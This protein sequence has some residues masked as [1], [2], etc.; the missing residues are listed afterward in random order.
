MK[1]EI[2]LTSRDL[3]TLHSLFSQYSGI[4]RVRIFGS[5]A[6]G[7]YRRGSDL[8]LVIDGVYDYSELQSDI[9]ES[10]LPYFVDILN[11]K[12]IWELPLQE[13]IQRVGKVIY[14]R[15]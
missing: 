3:D 11:P 12:D 14:I 4:Q 1:G 6:K 13:H 9:E 10:S 15:P 8:D 7:N 5:R 2:G